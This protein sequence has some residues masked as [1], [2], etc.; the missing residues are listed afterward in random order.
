MQDR[1][2]SSSPPPAWGSYEDHL[3]GAE[4]FE[5]FGI[6]VLVAGLDDL[7]SSKETL[8]RGKDTSILSELRTLRSRD[9]S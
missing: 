1:S 9:R 7:I 6:R 8:M 3:G 5:V 2:T 4:A